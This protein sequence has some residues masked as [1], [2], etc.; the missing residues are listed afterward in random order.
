VSFLDCHENSREEREGARSRG[1]IH[2]TQG[3]N[4]LRKGL[5]NQ[6]P[7]IN[8]EQHFHCSPGECIALMTDCPENRKTNFKNITALSSVICSHRGKKERA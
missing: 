6:A 3:V 5:I 2:Q 1:L 8:E 4:R 7:T